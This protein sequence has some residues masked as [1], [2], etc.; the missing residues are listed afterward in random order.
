MNTMFLFLKNRCVLDLLHLRRWLY[1]IGRVIKKRLMLLL[2]VCCLVPALARSTGSLTA[3]KSNLKNIATGLEMYSTDYKGTYPP[4]LSH[5]TPNYLKTIPHCPSA[6]YDTYSHTYYHDTEPEIFSIC[7]AGEHH[8]KVNV[9]PNC[10]A[11]DSI[12][13]ISA[14]QDE[15]SLEECKAKLSEKAERPQTSDP[16]SSDPTHHFLGNRCGGA[17]HTSE[18]CQAFFPKAGPGN[19][20]IVQTLPADAPINWKVLGG[21]VG[22][23]ALIGLARRF[24][25]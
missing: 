21:V 10:P 2:F 13:G 3:C 24:S 12:N 16:R 5:L 7:C 4:T 1:Y 17:F 15:V 23:L 25:G 22:V 9:P 18:G 20:V 14:R 6:G 19:E 8:T 11:Y